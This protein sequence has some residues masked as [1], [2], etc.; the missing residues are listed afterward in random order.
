MKNRKPQINKKQ[1]AWVEKFKAKYPEAKLTG[2]YEGLS[3]D[4]TV[5]LE[6]IESLPQIVLPDCADRGISW[7]QH[8]VQVKLRIFGDPRH[9]A[10]YQYLVVYP[11]CSIESTFKFSPQGQL[12]LNLGQLL[13]IKVPQ[14]PILVKPKKAN[15]KK[16]KKSVQFTLPLRGVAAKLHQINL[17]KN[18]EVIS[19]Q[20]LLSETVAYPDSETGSEIKLPAALV[21]ILEDK[22][23]SLKEWDD[24][25]SLYQ[26][27]GPSC[28]MTYLEGLD[29]IR[30]HFKY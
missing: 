13:N 17:S 19:E 11:H 16:L 25:I 26:V 1:R 30:E 2:I 12:S 27:G 20:E 7:I 14:N 8:T 9:S 5:K 22:K 29:S 28:L 24:A 21:E 18:R 15:Y 6:W 4:R 10:Q 23:A 3:G